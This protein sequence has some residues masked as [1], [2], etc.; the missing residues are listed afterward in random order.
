[1]PVLGH[2]AVAAT[3]LSV[4]AVPAATA[5][6]EVLAV[7]VALTTTAS[8]SHLIDIKTMDFQKV[9]ATGRMERFLPTKPLSELTVNELYNVTKINK[10]QTKYGSRIVVDLWDVP[11]LPPPQSTLPPLPPLPSTLPPLPPLPSPL[12]PSPPSPLTLLLLPIP[13]LLLLLP[14]PPPPPSPSLPPLLPTSPPSSTSTTS[15]STADLICYSE[16]PPHLRPRKL[17][18]PIR[19]PKYSPYFPPLRKQTRPLRWNN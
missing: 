11:P 17:L 12:P 3:V 16:P 8:S 7:L 18:S 15:T 10:V 19:S 5:S 2:I 4:S 1:M 6:T 14:P 13:L 9:N